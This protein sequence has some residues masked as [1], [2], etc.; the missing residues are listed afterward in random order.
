MSKDKAKIAL[1]KR[2]TSLN[3]SREFQNE[4][5]NIERQS[6]RSSRP[7]SILLPVELRTIMY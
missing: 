6:S 7:V 2:I 1:K 5:K 3:T 4:E